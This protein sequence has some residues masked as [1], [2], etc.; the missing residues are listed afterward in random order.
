MHGATTN[1]KELVAVIERGKEMLIVCDVFDEL[2][3]EK[4]QKGSVYI[5]LELLKSRLL[6]EATITVTSTSCPSVSAA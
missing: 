1:M 2:P 3:N 6:P 5:H 4:K